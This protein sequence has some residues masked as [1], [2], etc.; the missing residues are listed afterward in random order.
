MRRDFEEL[1]HE[2]K[3]IQNNTRMPPYLTLS[4]LGI[5]VLRRISDHLSWLAIPVKEKMEAFE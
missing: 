3:E 5:D 1:Y 2:Y 4:L